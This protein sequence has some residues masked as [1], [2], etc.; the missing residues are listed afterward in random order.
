MQDILFEQRAMSQEADDLRVRISKARL[1]L[2]ETTR[3][4]IIISKLLSKSQAI[5]QQSDRGNDVPLDTISCLAVSD[6]KALLDT[7][8]NVDQAQI[9]FDSFDEWF[10]EE[11]LESISLITCSVC[12]NVKIQQLV[13]DRSKISVNEFIRGLPMSTC[14]NPVCS[15]CYLESFTSSLQALR[16]A[17]W[18]IA[19]ST[20]SVPCPCGC[21]TDISIPDRGSLQRIL[22]L[23]GDEFPASKLRIY[24]TAQHL[25][26]AINGIDL[27]PTPKA[28]KAAQNLHQHL[29][30][31]NQMRSP[32]D[33]LLC[34]IQPRENGSPLNANFRLV[35]M[36]D[37]DGAEGTLS[38]PIFTRLLPLQ[39]TPSQCSI[40]T[41]LVRDCDYGC[42]DEWNAICTDYPG[43]WS[44]KIL[45]FPRKLEANC[46]HAID[47]CTACLRRHIE[48]QLDQHGRM[49]CRLLTCPSVGCGRRLEYEEVRLYAQDETFSK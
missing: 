49:G 26:A 43:D 20:I 3:R 12:H 35:Q 36:Y 5:C 41:E 48:S 16:E 44:W 40:C 15:N 11:N 42:L 33:L 19:G 24:D 29:I 8:L 25:M 10:G 34:E 9:L 37:L 23:A 13:D 28:R 32:F 31:N 30:T 45:L 17:W 27:Q 2:F 18:S 46:N 38:I 21:L 47:F 6:G 7:A 4:R 1:P 39:S 22:M 14:N